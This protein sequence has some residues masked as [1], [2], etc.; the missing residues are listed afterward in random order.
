MVKNKNIYKS[1]ENLKKI[2][3]IIDKNQPSFIYK[4]VPKE[5]IIKK[6]EMNYINIYKFIPP[7]NKIASVIHSEGQ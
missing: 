5:P 4:T 3:E 2:T 1:V 6:Q 7:I